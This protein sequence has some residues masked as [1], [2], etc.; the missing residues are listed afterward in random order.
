MRG[1]AMA[2][3]TVGYWNMLKQGKAT[4]FTDLFT[5]TAMV[6]VTLVLIAGGW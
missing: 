1:I 3:L 2:I 6:G 5:L 4:D